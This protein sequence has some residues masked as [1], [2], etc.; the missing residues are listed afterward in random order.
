MLRASS[1]ARARNGQNGDED[2]DEDGG[3]PP[4]IRAG[5]QGTQVHVHPLPSS[6]PSFSP[7]PSSPS[8]THPPPEYV[9]RQQRENG[10]FDFFKKQYRNIIFQR[11]KT[12]PHEQ[13]DYGTISFAH[14][15]LVMGPL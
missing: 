8:S 10:T 7:L 14:A 15:V 1:R 3:A 4:S 2:G 5:F 12:A 13:D 11:V 9:G 6:P